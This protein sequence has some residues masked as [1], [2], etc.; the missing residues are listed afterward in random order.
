MAIS[1]APAAPPQYS[2]VLLATDLGPASDVATERAIALAAQLGARLLVVNVI[3]AGRGLLLRPLSR[4]RPVEEREARSEAA[5][6]VVRHAR[7][8]GARATFLIW[9]GEP[10]DAILGAAAAEHAD[11]IVVG[12]RGRGAVGRLLGSVSDYVL[13]R[14]SVPV[15]VAR[16]DDSALE[17]GGS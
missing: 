1:V 5:Q 17:A 15:L 4:L 6:V 13:H 11:L 10:G 7:A 3:D 14:A 16:S 12:T 9:D 8:A 2:T